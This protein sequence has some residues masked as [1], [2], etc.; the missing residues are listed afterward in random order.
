MFFCPYIALNCNERPVARAWHPGAQCGDIPCSSAGISCWP[1]FLIMSGYDY[2]VSNRWRPTKQTDLLILTLLC[3]TEGY[4]LSCLPE[5]RQQRQ[6]QT[7]GSESKRAGHTATKQT[8][9]AMALGFH[10]ARLSPPGSAGLGGKGDIFSKIAGPNS[11]C[12]LTAGLI[13]EKKV[14]KERLLGDA[15]ESHMLPLENSQT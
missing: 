2:R 5:P 9:E 14:G 8:P 1:F 4:R 3:S 11:G 7:K 12:M 10:T 13:K 6:N 15:S